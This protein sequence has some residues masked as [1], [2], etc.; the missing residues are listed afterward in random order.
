MRKD[1]NLNSKI[2]GIPLCPDIKI[3]ISIFDAEM[4]ISKTL[5][6]LILTIF[7]LLIVKG[8]PNYSLKS[9]DITEGKTARL[10]NKAAKKSFKKGAYNEGLIHV[11]QALKKAERDAGCPTL[12]GL[13]C[14]PSNSRAHDLA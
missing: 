12:G 5:L 6:T 4:K 1:G 13:P 2:I 8:Q 11:A 14:L 10:S 3:I 7:T 9:H